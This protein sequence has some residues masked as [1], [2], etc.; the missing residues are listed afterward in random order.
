MITN[1]IL[2]DNWVDKM[3]HWTSE[4]IVN[5]AKRTDVATDKIVL[6]QTVLQ[7]LLDQS[8][9]L[10]SP[11]IFRL[12]N[13]GTGNYTHVGVREFSAPYG[14][15]IL[16][17]TVGELLSVK[18]NDSVVAEMVEL[19]K[20]TK[21]RLEPL[22]G[23]YNVDDWKS[24]LEAQLNTTHTALTKGNVLTVTDPLR[25]ENTFEFKIQEL[26]PAEAVCIVDTDVELEIGEPT[27]FQ[28]QASSAASGP[29]VVQV[30]V[31]LTVYLEEA[32]TKLELKDWDRSKPI[33]FS[34]EEDG[35]DKVAAALIGIDDSTNRD[36]FIWST[37][38][39]PVT[40]KPNDPFL[41]D[42]TSTLYVT[43]L[44][45]TVP[46][47][48]TL[49]ALQH[50]APITDNAGT[51]NID[52]DPA[53]SICPNCKQAIPAQSLTLHSAFCARNN[54]PCDCGKIFQKRIPDTHWHCLEHGMDGNSN[55]SKQLH[56]QYLHEPAQCKCGD[57]DK[58][59]DPIFS[60]KVTLGLH[61]AT[62]CPLALHIC[63]FCHLKLPRGRST[64]VDTLS[65]LSAH[66]SACGSKTTDCY[67]CG[68]TI[69]RR[70]L[71]SHMQYHDMDR[72]AQTAPAICTNKNC[73]R[74]AGD[75]DLG[76]CT[77]C[78]G[79]LHSTLYDPTGA[80]LQ[81]RIERRY[82]IQLT[83]GCGNAFC[84]NPQCK[85]NRQLAGMAQ[86][87]PVVK[88]LMALGNVF[89]FCVDEMTTKR[90]M[91]V[92]IEVAEGEYEAGWCVKAI[93]KA[94]GNEQEARNWLQTHAVK[95]T[96]Q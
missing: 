6:P 3:I 72:L 23:N 95:R 81:S 49:K 46:M 91:F 87:V 74:V 10:P 47:K 57:G 37:L 44:A 11:L 25:P 59:E 2:L 16:P 17:S 33:E 73:A 80:K 94:K 30:D 61:R 32:E 26:E 84:V 51:T 40:I 66:E 82:V 24:M 67:L 12:T 93:D 39:G 21:L 4:L 20:G 86:V 22:R 88:E 36:N 52:T 79:P 89:Y 92:D 78:Y 29:I 64:A 90:K 43:V 63:R 34:M 42:D 56:S 50:G 5:I 18:V 19:P 60:S 54:V 35:D 55:D 14:V 70:E 53:K 31:P 62:E 65:G 15:A 45:Q 77:F 48:I 96:E 75:N 27:A 68:R 7:E 9:E 13:P 1:C 28:T 83:R 41:S 58:E 69:R 71:N 8:Q 76:L 38:L 85:M